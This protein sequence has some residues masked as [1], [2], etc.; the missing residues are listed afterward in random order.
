M[1][2]SDWSS[3]VCSSDLKLNG[4]PAKSISCGILSV[5]LLTPTVNFAFHGNS[6]LACR[7]CVSQL[8]VALEPVPAVEAKA[9][10]D[11]ANLRLGRLRVRQEDA[12]RA[13]LD[14]RGRHA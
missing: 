5:T 9:F 7:S 13:A 3:D 6:T 1:R 10:V 8:S 14:D 11:G 4:R 12:A 2:I